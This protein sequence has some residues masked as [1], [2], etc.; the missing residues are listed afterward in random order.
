MNS[1]GNLVKEDPTPA[2]CKEGASVTGARKKR[3]SRLKYGEEGRTPYV[4]GCF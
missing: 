3:A 2:V 4:S 1:H